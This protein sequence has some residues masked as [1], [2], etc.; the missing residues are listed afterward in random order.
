MEIASQSP[1]ELIAERL[2]DALARKNL[3][4]IDLANHMGLSEAAVV[5]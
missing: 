4:Q 3:R 5:S 1:Q 2:A